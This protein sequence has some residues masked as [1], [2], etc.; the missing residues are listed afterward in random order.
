M[1]HALNIDRKSVVRKPLLPELQLVLAWVTSLLAFSGWSHFWMQLRGGETKI[2]I[3]AHFL[4]LPIIDRRANPVVVG[5]VG[6]VVL[7]MA[8]GFQVI[9]LCFDLLILADQPLDVGAGFVSGREAAWLYYHT[10]LNSWHVNL[11]LAIFLFVCQFG[12]LAGFARSSPNALRW[13]RGLVVTMI[14]GNGGYLA[15]VVPRYCNVRF[16]PTFD[17]S[18]FDGWSA[19]LAARL[20]LFV[21]LG[22]AILCV[23]SLLLELQREQQAV[24][25]HVE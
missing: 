25:R 13:W 1:T 2:L 22:C 7:G 3:A 23:C 15:A 14:I 10:M 17:R 16:S 18:F 12:A 11:A 6:C 24:K 8:T 4:T 19:V 5:A 9:D 21:C 20:W